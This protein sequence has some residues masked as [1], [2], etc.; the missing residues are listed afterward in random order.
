[1]QW[2]EL[3]PVD[4]VE[5]VK[6]ARGVCLLPIGVIEPH[7]RLP[8]GAELFEPRTIA[9]RAARRE[10]AVV[11]PWYYFGQINATRH[12]PGT[13]SVRGETVVSLLTE[14]CLEIS[15]NGLKKIVI[16]NGHGATDYLTFFLSSMLEQKRDFTPYLINW[17]EGLEGGLQFDLH[18]AAELAIHRNLVKLEQVPE[19]AYDPDLFQYDHLPGLACPVPKY[20][21]GDQLRDGNLDA[22]EEGIQEGERLLDAAAD[23]LAGHIRAVK[24]D[25][26]TARRTAQFFNESEHDDS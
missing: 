11:F 9:I 24:K 17:W 10:P 16:V 8:L 23:N 12:I 18:V 15:R 3:T 20:G 4:F 19:E 25:Q 14:V 22:V 21:G 2:E 7:P 13:V 1:M 26:V 5:A 6:R